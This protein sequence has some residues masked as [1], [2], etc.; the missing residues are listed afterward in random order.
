MAAR[1]DTPRAVSSPA[2][3]RGAMK[4][5]SGLDERQRQAVATLLDGAQFGR[6]LS[7]LAEAGIGSKSISLLAGEAGMPQLHERRTKR[8]LENLGQIESI[9]ASGATLLAAGPLAGLLSERLQGESGTVG[10]LLER[11]L[12]KRHADYL[13]EHMDAGEI[14]LWVRVNDGEEES[15]VCRTLLR[16]SAGQVQVHDIVI[17]RGA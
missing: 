8:L 1:A 15:R 14:L 11:W 3:D 12:T 2:R 5:A 9:E 17:K 4:P 16:H 13:Q 7:A 6:A 10:S